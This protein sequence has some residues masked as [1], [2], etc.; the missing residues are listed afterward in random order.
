MVLP[1]QNT[2]IVLQA[3]KL[4]SDE[5]LYPIRTYILSTKKNKPQIG[6]QSFHIFPVHRFWNVSFCILYTQKYN[7]FML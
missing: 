6:R 5:L 3:T 2:D 4:S 1:A 7:T